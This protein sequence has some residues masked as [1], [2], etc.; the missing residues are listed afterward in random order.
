MQILWPPVAKSC[1]IGKYPDAGKDWRRRRKGRQRMRCLD[2]ITDSTDV[3]LSEL[4]E[5]VVDRKA[6]R[7]AVHG[8]AEN[9]TRLSNWTEL[10]WYL[11][12][13]IENLVCFLILAS[14]QP[15][16]IGIFKLLL[17]FYQWE[18]QRSCQSLITGW[19]IK[20]STFSTRHLTW[21]YTL[22]F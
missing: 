22:D 13:H 20:R 8:V 10:N 5:L 3:S 15:Y 21:V 11:L 14:E 16:I 9:G 2:G 1:L 7:A 18:N 12:F 17:L 6:W 19:C 4:R